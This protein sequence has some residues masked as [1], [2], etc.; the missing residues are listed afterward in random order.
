[1]EIAEQSVLVTG[2]ASGIG[3]AVARHFAQRG[4]QVG[5]LDRDGDAAEAVAREI[6]G[7]GLHA[8]VADPNEVRAA[9]GALEERFGALRVCVHC[10]GIGPARRI[11]GRDGV[12]PL[13]EFSRVVQVN[14]VGTFNVLRLAAERMAEHEPMGASGERGVIINTASIAAFE[15]QVGQAAYAASKGGVVAMTLPAAR[16]LAQ[17]GIRVVTIAPGLVETPMLR[18]L[19]EEIQQGLAASV[20][21]PRRLAQPGE[22]ARLAEHIAAN[23]YL[24]GEVIRLDGALRMAPR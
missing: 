4:A 20:P 19:P 3:E 18:A 13:E 9:I 5:V 16:E 7:I 11:L 6:G 15:G 10:A 21:F 1:M 17:F 23:E 12:M 2:A 24:N 22:F 8:D 14:L